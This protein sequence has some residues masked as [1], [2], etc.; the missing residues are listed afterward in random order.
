[1][2]PSDWNSPSGLIH[3]RA[4]RRIFAF[5]LALLVAVAAAPAA[6]PDAAATQEALFL[7]NPPPTSST[8]TPER[9]G[10]F[11]P[12]GTPLDFSKRTRA[13]NPFFQIYILDLTT[14]DTTR[15]S[16]G[17]GK[18][19]GSFFQPGTS[20]V[21]FASTH[22][23]PQAASKMK[24]EFE[25]RAKGPGRRYSW[26]YDETYDIFPAKATAPICGASRRAAD[27]MPK[28]RFH[29]DGKKIVFS[30]IRAAY[31]DKNL[32][33]RSSAAGEGSGLL[34]GHIRHERR[35]QRRAA[36]D[37][38]GRVRW[39]S[40]FMPDGQRIVWRR[41]EPDGLNADVYT[42]RTDGSDVQRI[43]NFGAMSWGRF[44]I[45][46]AHIFISPRANS[47]SRTLNSSSSMLRARAS[48]CAFLFRR[49][50]TVSPRF[51]SGRKETLLDFESRRRQAVAAFHCRLES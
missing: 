16:P 27:T 3:G 26:D 23:D 4:M 37:A 12:D 31:S 42:M 28:D 5:S 30:S 44:R 40:L 36:I 24:A 39:R 29:P 15:V 18:T 19:T 35:R 8:T 7:R 21:L 48:L 10:Y 20:R 9:R 11:H 50:L 38:N 1:M 41:F 6:D 47:D 2:T 33:R 46:A 14:G 34:C 13:G 32:R 22:L 43:T 45:P 17:I 49:A 51:F 25:V